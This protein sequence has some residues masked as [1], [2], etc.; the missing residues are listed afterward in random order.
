[1]DKFELIKR[2]VIKDNPDFEKISMQFK[3][4]NTKYGREATNLIFAR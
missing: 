2:I 3:F 4:E 1:M